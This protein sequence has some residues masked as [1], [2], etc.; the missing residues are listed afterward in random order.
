MLC[1]RFESSIPNCEGE[2]FPSTETNANASMARGR[3][4]PL[5]LEEL[6]EAVSITP[7]ENKLNRK[8]VVS[9]PSALIRICTPLI[10]VS[11]GTGE[12]TLC[13]YS[14]KEFLTRDSNSFSEALN[15]QDNL[16]IYHV[17]EQSAH[18]EI[19]QCCLSCLLFDSFSEPVNGIDNLTRRQQD[20]RLLDYATLFV[21]EHCAELTTC[22]H[23][24]TSYLDRLF[25][26]E[27]LLSSISD[28][29][30]ELARKVEGLI[31]LAT[32]SIFCPS[33]SD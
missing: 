4:A 14:A 29:D 24:V 20:Y 31:G 2:R 8:Q 10:H 32:V 16:R 26:P 33:V 3:K 21:G 5:W 6:S 13:H 28:P 27:L 19:T 7:G 22:S 17:D 9:N 23:D 12:V 25:F 11:E 1:R 15:G 18:G 30:P